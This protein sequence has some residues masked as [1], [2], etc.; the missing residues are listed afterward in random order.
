MAA[1]ASPLGADRAGG[2]TDG[3]LDRYIAAFISSPRGAPD[4]CSNQPHLFSDRGGSC[5]AGGGV[6]VIR[7][8]PLALFWREMCFCHYW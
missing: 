6:D 2:S 3:L 7:E 1:G 8:R 5:L 4:G